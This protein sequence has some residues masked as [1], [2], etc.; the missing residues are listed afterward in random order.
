MMRRIT[1]LCIALLLCSAAWADGI[2][3][4]GSSGG[5]GTGCTPGGASGAVQYNDSGSCGGISG[6]TTDGTT[7]TLVAPVLGTP[8]SGVATN[9]TGTAAGLTA[10]HVTTNANLT[11]PITSSGNAT[12]I[13]S[14]TGTGT[15]FVVDTGPTIAGPTL[16]GSV[17]LS[18]LAGGGTQCVQTNNSG[19]LAA[20]GSACGSGGGGI[21]AL[22][23]DVT[24]SGSGSVAAT[25]AT[26]QPAVH[27]WALAQ[28][29][30][31]APVFTDA[32][33]SRTALGLG[34]LATQ[35]S[36]A[37][38]ITG[39]AISGV[40]LS[41]LSIALE[42]SSS[43]SVTLTVPAAAGSN[44]LTFPAGTTNFSSTGGT[45]QVV[46]QTSSGGAF[47]VA[48]LA[49]TDMSGTVAVAQL[50]G[51]PASHAVPV[52][53]A[54]TSTYK[55]IPDCTD[56]GGNHLNYTQSSDAFSCG[57]SGGGGITALTGDVTA[58][59]TGS[60]AATLATTQSAAHTWSVAG[61]ASTPAMFYTGA[62]Y[63]AGTGTTNFPHIFLQPTGTTAATNLSTAGTGLGMNLA[64]GFAG[65][66]LDFK[67]AGVGRFLVDSDGSIFMLDAAN[68]VNVIN[69]IFQNSQTVG[70]NGFRLYNGFV[71]T[72]VRGVK[73]VAVNDPS[74]GTEGLTLR[75]TGSFCWAPSSTAE[76]T[77]CDTM[78]NR[79]GAAASVQQGAADVD[80][81]SAIVAQTYR[82]QGALAGGTSNQAGKNFTM[83][84]SPGKG[85]GAGGSFIVQTAPAGSTG[86]TLNAPVTAMTIDSAALATFAGQINVA[87]MTQTSA[88]Q[89]GTVC[90]NSGTGAI[91]YDATLGCLASTMEV[92]KNWKDISP[93]DALSKV[94]KMRAGS[95]EYRD[96]LGLPVGEQVGL[97][98]QQIETIDT[99]L[100][101]YRPNGDLA[102]VR[103]S[104]ASALYPMAIQAL[105]IANDNLRAE[106][107]RLKVKIGDR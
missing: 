81:N 98:A 20:T 89:S 94:L 33:G 49:F 99:R 69:T 97:S 58:S 71:T 36:G 88:A 102:G 8:A 54:G 92:K 29:F 39:G 40:T 10:G 84:V 25:L 103:Y 80:L 2:V 75:S 47:T 83:I 5:G 96:G 66:F 51:S 106:V 101:G 27:T 12:A 95:F 31:V 37:V 38:T 35:N 48:Q 11:G 13:A 107:D 43:G 90:Y 16:S 22:T 23:G 30:T 59:G 93:Q 53:V 3:N 19:V 56:T 82:T 64:S 100:V 44:T 45:S 21:T 105:K 1:A 63:A 78:L 57:T 76:G 18:G 55:V 86:T 42:G 68:S 70:N 14:Q 26:A 52:D 17:T 32:S 60:V 65:N 4:G 24:A 74:G 50:G 104:Q 9:L 73:Y 67:R 91:T 72:L 62:I 87:A 85:T 61:A 15:K 7:L 77:S 34:T 79:G 6:A 28:T 46:K 41:G